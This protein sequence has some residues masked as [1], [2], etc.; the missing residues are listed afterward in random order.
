MRTSSAPVLADRSVRAEDVATSDLH[1]RW[2]H[3][4]SFSDLHDGGYFRHFC[5][6]FSFC[7]I[8][9]FQDPA[10]FYQSFG[11]VCF[12]FDSIPS[13]FVVLLVMT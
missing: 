11:F 8:L 5:I 2:C 10:W 12:S 4:A 6:I 3:S 1:A 13:P 7:L 9:Y